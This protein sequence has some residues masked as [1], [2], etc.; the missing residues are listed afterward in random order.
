MPRRARRDLKSKYTH[1]IVQG[2]NK[3]Y[4]FEEDKLKNI[5]MKIL[6]KNL[7]NTQVKILSYCIMGNHVHTLV[8]SEKVS[9][10]SKFMQKSNTEYAMKYNKIKKRVGYVFRDRYYSQDILSEKQLFNC[11]AYIH[12]NPIKA[13]IV[14]NFEEYKYS[15]YN[16]YM[17]EQYL[18]SDD[19]KNLIFGNDNDFHDIFKDMH[20]IFGNENDIMDLPDIS[21]VKSAVEVINTYVNKKQI[22][23]EEIKLNENCLRELLITLQNECK[24]SLRALGELFGMGKDKIRKIIKIK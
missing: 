8:H 20:Q 14:E 18:I 16:E 22:S 4:I 13:G 5:Y 6:K 19:A 23:I 2:I 10:I 15:S 12:K 1:V 7:E 3:E 11:V 24:L 17:G 9:E 21:E